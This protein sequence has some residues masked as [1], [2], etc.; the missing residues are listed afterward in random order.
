LKSTED[1]TDGVGRNVDDVAMA[2]KSSLPAPRWAMSNA[3][4]AT[5]LLVAAVFAFFTTWFLLSPFVESVDRTVLIMMVVGNIVIAAGFA[6]LV[7]IRLWD[8][9]A[10]RRHARAG[11]QTHLQLI[12]LFSI[13]A[14][15]PAIFAFLF[16]FTIL[17][18]SLNDVFSERIDN[19]VNTARDFANTYFQ[20]EADNTGLNLN[21]LA[22]DLDRDMQFGVSP[23]AAPITFRRRLV[24]QAL[25]R[26]LSA[27]IVMDG[28]RQ[29]LARVELKPGA[30]KLPPVEVFDQVDAAAV[31]DR[32]RSEWGKF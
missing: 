13:F 3:T 20:E 15:A 17:R 31:A 30:Y 2:R 29:V 27:L 22:L 24:Q 1:M 28:Q 25:V 18:A 5:G 14:A 9:L 21:Q 6:T 4:A 12:G 8:V 16:A 23:E 11:S 32:P 19:Y 10:E 26:D 7:G